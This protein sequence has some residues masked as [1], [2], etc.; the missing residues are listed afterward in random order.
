MPPWAV[1]AWSLWQDDG[2]LFAFVSGA[3]A[4]MDFDAW[5]IHNG[6]S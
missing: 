3:S 2:I 5:L 1:F 6:G 4:N